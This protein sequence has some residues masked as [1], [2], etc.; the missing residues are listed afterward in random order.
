VAFAASEQL[1]AGM[2]GQLG[3]RLPEDLRQRLMRDNGGEVQA[4]GEAWALY[5]VWDPTDRK[6]IGRTA[7]HIARENEAIRRDAPGALPPGYLAVADNGGGDLLVIAPGE[8]AIQLWDHE[9]GVITA[10]DVSWT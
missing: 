4:A 5:P 1:V 9:T 10:A 3:R 8:D 6:T 7:N 2:E